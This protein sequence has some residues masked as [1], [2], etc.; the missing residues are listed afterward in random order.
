MGI[1]GK[2]ATILNIVIAVS[3][4]LEPLSIFL[5]KCRGLVW[6]NFVYFI[7]NGN[8]NCRVVRVSGN[9]AILYLRLNMTTRKG[10]HKSVF[11]SS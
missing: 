4:V 8:K 11:V 10:K 9:T 1:K 6:M 2:N 7:F 3:V 5:L